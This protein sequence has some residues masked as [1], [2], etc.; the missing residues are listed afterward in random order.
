[1]LV[2]TVHAL[3]ISIS[4]NPAKSI[5]TTGVRIE[6]NTDVDATTRVDYG[7][8]TQLG[9]V[10]EDLAFTKFH[11]VQLDGLLPNTKYYFQLV[12]IDQSG[13]FKIA[14]NNGN[15]YFFTTSPGA[16]AN[17]PT[18]I[19]V[20]ATSFS[21]TS[22]TF[23]WS[24]NEPASTI[25]SF[26]EGTP[27]QQTVDQSLVVE[28]VATI[29]TQAGKLYAFVVGG[30]DQFENCG[31]ASGIEFLAGT[32]Q[33]AP[34]LTAD[35]PAKVR[36]NKI[37][38]KGT[39]RPFAKI[40]V[41]VN[42]LLQKTD[43]AEGNGA[44]EIKNLI[45]T[46]PVNNTL[47][48]VVTDAAGQT[49]EQTY[50]IT[51]DNTPPNVK[52]RGIPAIASTTPITISGSTNEHVTITHEVKQ[53]FDTNAPSRVAGLKGEKVTSG[54]V[55]LVWTENDEADI[56]EYAVYRNSIR[57]ATT[58]QPTYTDTVG[59]GTTYQYRIS[60]VDTS[61]NEG[62][63][64]EPAF[65]QTPA[66]EK[67]GEPTGVELTCKPQKQT[68]EASGDFSFAVDL[69]DGNN[70]I[71][72]T[73]KDDAG[74][75]V[76]FQ[77]S[78]RLDN[79]A[80]QFLEDNLNRLSPTYI[81]EVTVK[82]KVS[83]KSTV[84]VYVNDDSKPQA[85]EVTGDD[86]SFSIKVKLSRSATVSGN[87]SKTPTGAVVVETGI[88][89]FKNKIRIEAVDLAGLKTSKGP[90]D[91]LYTLCGEG[92]WFKVDIGEISPSVVTP[93]LVIE[94]VQQLGL[95][96]NISYRGAHKA[97]IQRVTVSH[98]L[99]SPE[100]QD[101]YDADWVQLNP[102]FSRKNWGAGYLQ[103]AFNA[104][105]PAEGQTTADK[106]DE[107]AEH[108]KGEECKTPGVGCAR[109]LL[110]V[111]IQAQEEIPKRFSDIRTDT[112]T[113]N[114]TIEPIRQKVCVPVEVMMDVPIHLSEKIPKKLLESASAFLTST[115]D[116]IDAILK[117]LTTIGTYTLYTCFAMTAWNF[118]QFLQEDIACGGSV[119]TGLLSGGSSTFDVR[120]A[121]IG[122]CD[123]VYPKD[124]DSS[125][126]DACN[127][128]Q[129]AIDSRVSFE[130]TLR[131]VC[132]RVACPSAPTLQ[133]YINEKP[134]PEFVAG[135]PDNTKLYKG[136]SCGFK[137]T[138][139]TGSAGGVNTTATKLGGD[140][141]TIKQTYFDFLTHKDD[142]NKKKQ[143]G[144]PQ[145]TAATV[146]CA[147]LHPANS[148]CCGFE[149][150][151]EWGSAC[152]IPGL[153]ETFDEI[154]Q[155]ACLAAQG[156]NSIPTFEK[157][158]S[159]KKKGAPVKC[160]SLFNSLAGFCE[161]DGA[162][163]GDTIA[164]GI[165]YGA[166]VVPQS[167]YSNEMYVRI[168]PI[169]AN[170][171][172]Q[173]RI[174]RGYVRR[175]LVERKATIDQ[176]D[177][178]TE[179][180][181][182]N[183]NLEFTQDSGPNS[184]LTA[185]FSDPKK[186]RE[187]G[188]RELDAALCSWNVADAP[189]CHSNV[190]GRYDSIK[191]KIGITDKAYIVRP[192]Q[193]GIL[194]S[195]QCVCLPAVTSYLSFWRTVLSNVKT[196]VDHIRLT[197][198]GSSGVCQ[199]VL[200]T[201]VC[202]LL[203]DL[204]R[205][206]VQKFGD[207]GE[208]TRIGSKGIGDVLGSLTR[209]GG[210]MQQSVQG[211]YGQTALWKT[212]FNDRKIVHSICAFAFTG[213]WDLNVQGIFEQTVQDIPIQSQGV[214]YP[215]DRRYVAY[216]PLSTPK[217]LVTW[218]YHFGVGLVAGA[219]LQYT[220]SL[221]CSNSLRCEERD[222]FKDGKCD[223]LGRSEIVTPINPAELGTGD[224]SKNDVLNTEIFF[225]VQAGEP[226]SEIRYDT[227]ILEWEYKDNNGQLQKGKAEQKI[228]LTGGDAPNFC[229]LQLLDRQLFLC[230]FGVG[231]YAGVSF[232]KDP[233]LKNPP[234]LLGKPI[235]FTLGLNLFGSSDPRAQG[236]ATTGINTKFLIY[237][238]R[239]GLGTIIKTN[240]DPQ[241]TSA[242]IPIETEGE[243]EK[244]VTI[245]PVTD[246]DFGVT[247]QQQTLIDRVSLEDKDLKSNDPRLYAKTF[248]NPTTTQFVVRPVPGGKI[249]LLFV[250]V[251]GN[252]V[253]VY[254]TTNQ[255]V[256]NAPQ[257]DAQNALTG[258]WGYRKKID[259]DDNTA[260]GVTPLKTVDLV[261]NVLTYTDD[262]GAFMSNAQFK[263]AFTKLPAQNG[264]MRLDYTEPSGEGTPC[265]HFLTAPDTWKATFT[266]YDS[267]KPQ[268]GGFYEPNFDQVATDSSGVRQERTVSVQAVCNTQ[269]AGPVNVTTGAPGLAQLRFCD[270][271]PALS[272]PNACYCGTY[273]NALRDLQ[274]GIM[275]HNCGPANEVN[276]G[277]NYCTYSLN[278]FE[279]P[280]EFEAAND[281]VCSSESQNVPYVKS[282]EFVRMIDNAFTADVLSVPYGG[283]ITLR[284]NQTYGWRAKLVSSTAVRVKSG[285]QGVLSLDEQTIDAGEKDVTFVGPGASVLTISFPDTQ[286]R[287]YGIWVAEASAL[288]RGSA[289]PFTINVVP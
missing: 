282:T 240:R 46:Q 288:S 103:I 26:G 135:L 165:H 228:H 99:L 11:R 96:L 199:A 53:A 206:F 97:V 213:T 278:N 138:E 33:G 177:K 198:E 201:Y 117:P 212:M 6:W 221:K 21:D 203:Y 58:Q 208:G 224:L 100:E 111:E 214:V 79:Q 264:E 30:C 179:G 232:T 95:P 275:K 129:K 162:P 121:E 125:K 63:Q 289:Y 262:K 172:K 71:R 204:L 68:L 175:T 226:G 83:E 193:E 242:P 192:D 102:M 154:E 227:A 82:G 219:D 151:D 47:K 91:V 32:Q 197:G 25:V 50:P 153:V 119:V 114:V 223:C 195:V 230:Q 216:N 7:T 190:G 93:R 59:G 49:V 239:N 268:Y 108:R 243:H 98:L 16:D 247:S 140:Y 130:G 122:S 106:E 174:T 205:C 115:I 4:G 105:P 176:K 118:V 142:A 9:S 5:N 57:V 112:T 141:T 238:L 265:S 164:T 27:T 187:A 287:N 123:K 283:T 94:G 155:S 64:S 109:F 40:E 254:K 127:K 89:G 132:D 51:I 65:V 159:T 182:L 156:A 258:E 286:P 39:T 120:V 128:C 2:T 147:G 178:N 245:T 269:Y 34:P 133:T 54:T 42:N 261:N 276:P 69:L 249:D 225:P 81:P 259:G 131:K 110:Q 209:A 136:N 145:G 67:R 124:Q 279:T 52:I 256:Q 253:E 161:K 196:C 107:I 87:A 274:L 277:K 183:E 244:T 24:T 1:M 235:D 188:V 218:V 236:G 158:A 272:Q 194:R 257:K 3:S 252:K 220:L 37:D 92:S 234:I 166:G 217:G 160:N 90:V 285:L 263:L 157:E 116:V 56:H 267:K 146:N 281:R 101:K 284:A 280:D 143:T 229:K 19:D 88:G 14:N 74:N 73:A 18:F 113:G 45:L 173:Y 36:Q 241:G 149:Y 231:D 144:T 78:T 148:Q 139:V 250:F 13:E 248:L 169:P 233:A 61:C 202:D 66:G 137:G 15:Y 104:Q 10:K 266:L 76:V 211:R 150:Y 20:R 271:N 44:F 38:I 189:T 170:D 168:D 251:G 273:A 12:S 237:E 28:H 126:N 191:G 84:F 184:D 80:P 55:E 31:N 43:Y 22:T 167:S 77:N 163:V 8:T 29:P 186:T 171:P 185:I 134:S 255:P 72:I 270:P 23:K 35:V 180:R 200:S 222:G 215:A 62:A 181:Y 152:G 75:M 70:Q 210:R 41:S 246:K 207:S 60:A 86:G 85:F 48:I 17:A 260:N